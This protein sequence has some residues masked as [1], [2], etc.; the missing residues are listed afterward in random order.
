MKMNSSGNWSPSAFLRVAMATFGATAAAAKGDRFSAAGRRYG[1][2]SATG[3]LIAILI[4]PSPGGAHQH[5]LA[6][7]F[8][9]NESD[10]AWVTFDRH[11]PISTCE[12]TAQ[13]TC[14]ILPARAGRYVVLSQQMFNSVPDKAKAAKELK[15][16]LK[17]GGRF[18]VSAWTV[19]PQGTYIRLLSETFEKHAPGSAKAPLFPFSGNRHELEKAFKDAGFDNLEVEVV[20]M[21]TP[22]KEVWTS[23]VDDVRIFG[24]GVFFGESGPSMYPSF[25]DPAVVDRVAEDVASQL[26][27]PVRGPGTLVFES[28]V[29]SGTK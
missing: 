17:D 26:E 22:L 21:D 12:T 24:G 27:L 20:R 9:F 5:W 16:V 13:G 7:S 28:I 10:T 15:R 8:F 1:R 18:V 29:I 2:L 6:P 11:D 14:E 19:Q 4:S 23:V 25:Q 3:S